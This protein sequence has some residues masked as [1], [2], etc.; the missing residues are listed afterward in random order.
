[1]DNDRSGAHGS[2]LARDPMTFPWNLALYGLAG[3]GDLLAT[4][5]S[6]LSRNYRF[7]LGLAEGLSRPEALSRVGATVEG[8]GTTD[9]VLRLAEQHGWHLPI[10]SEVAALM[11]GRS[12][13]SAAVRRLM[14]RDLREERLAVQA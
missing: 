13:A 9:A 12:S 11:A 14:E 6:P 10:C 5:N 8:A 2:A 3:L 1:M 7:G 4:A